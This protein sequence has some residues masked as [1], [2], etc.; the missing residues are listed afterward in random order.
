[1]HRHMKKKTIIIIIDYLKI[2]YLNSHKI[3]NI[4]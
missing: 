3:N 1:M 4:L 2:N